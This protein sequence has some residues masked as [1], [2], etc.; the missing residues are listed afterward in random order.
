VQHRTERKRSAAKASQTAGELAFGSKAISVGRMDVEDEVNYAALGLDRLAAQLEKVLGQTGE[1][2]IRSPHR[3]LK[4]GVKQM[5]HR[6]FLKVSA[7]HL[8]WWLG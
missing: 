4:H 3:L 8:F 2:V 6:G 5:A 1:N 7:V